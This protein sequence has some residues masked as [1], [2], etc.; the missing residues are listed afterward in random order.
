ME[1]S[2]TPNYYKKH[3]LVFRNLARELNVTMVI[4]SCLNLCVENREGVAEKFPQLSDLRYIGDLDEISDVVL[5]V[6]R[7]V[8]YGITVMN[9]KNQTRTLYLSLLKTKNGISSCVMDLEINAD[10]FSVF[11]SE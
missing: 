1:D 6:F 9:E 3:A 8:E 11:T 10:T 4:T 5:G 2:C 7:L